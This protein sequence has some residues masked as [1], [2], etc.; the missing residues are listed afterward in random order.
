MRVL[1]IL[2]RSEFLKTSEAFVVQMGGSGDLAPF[3]L[4]SS[5]L[6]GISNYEPE[7]FPLFLGQGGGTGLLGSFLTLETAR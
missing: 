2:G 6:W 1:E 3:S 4:Q 5:F 7:L